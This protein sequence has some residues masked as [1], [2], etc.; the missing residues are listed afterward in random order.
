MIP[1]NRTN[2]VAQKALALYPVPN[3]TGNPLTGANNFSGSGDVPNTWDQF[4]VRVDH[5]IDAKNRLFARFSYSNISRGSYDFFHD[6]A[7]GVDPG[8]GDVPAIS[9]GRNAVLDY[10]NTISPTL[11][12]EFRYGFVRAWLFKNPEGTGLDLTT[13][14][15]PAVLNQELPL[16]AYPSFQ[17]SGF[18][19]I[20]PEGGDLLH[21][22]DNTHVW[23]GSLT[24]VLSK[25][26]LKFGGDYRFMPLND[27]QPGSP[28]PV[29][30]FTAGFTQA[31]PLSASATSGNSIASFLLGY[32]SSGS[33]DNTPAISYSYRYLGGYLQDDYKVTRKLTL[34]LGIR[35][36]LETGRNERYN[37]LSWFNPA[38][39]NP[40]G[41][42]VGLP[43]LQ[44]GLEFVGVDGNP[45]RQKATNYNNWG[46]R[47]GFAYSLTPNTVVRGGY[48]LFFLPATG[49]DSGTNVG[50]S[51]FF[52]TTT[53]VSSLNGGI[54]P[55]SSL[56]NPFPTGII[57]PPGSS[58]GLLTLLGQD[59]VSV[60]HNDRSGYAQEW[61]LDIQRQLP[62]SFFF[63]IAYAGNKGTA[64]PVDIQADQLADQYLAM[65]SALLKQVPNPFYGIVTSGLQSGSTVLAEQLLRPFPQYDSVNVR[66]VHE[67]DSIYHALQT[68]LEHRFS[69]GLSLQA[70][71]VYSKVISN[72]PSRLAVN[73][74][75]PGIQDS[76]NLRAER[77]L[78]NIDVPQRFVVSYIYE[79]PFGPG[80]PILGFVGPTLGKIV[81]G[82]QLNGVTTFQGG[83]P[84]GLTTSVNQ[85]NSLGGGSRPNNNGTTQ[86]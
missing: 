52:A 83:V 31:N 80:K 75:N 49:D 43:S 46:P 12:F 56:S 28:Q 50:A 36:E 7:G 73:L 38:V 24:K 18:E 23:Q 67:A 79:L 10:T 29:F 77:S 58:Q 17:P 35:Y 13:L 74:A 57:Q 63:D 48:G 37:R 26:I 54:T 20:A 41:P 1:A 45:V 4:T 11:L 59:L 47:A 34:N 81:G 2:P 64:L 78:A 5:I 16:R 22:G 9:D 65:G 44:G 42:Q 39:A 40:I 8:G 85:T 82:W 84:L 55:A 68:K 72:A 71:Y 86:P 15:F 25:H 61:N 60:Y 53:F 19:G 66:A 30:N 6:G 21:R 62:A 76:N 14:G 32:P 51:G 70:S 3:A 27:L 69:H 33:V